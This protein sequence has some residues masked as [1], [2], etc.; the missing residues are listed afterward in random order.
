MVL[1]ILYA[2]YHDKTGMR[3]TRRDVRVLQYGCIGKLDIHFGCFALFIDFF[4]LSP[5][6][7]RR[8]GRSARASVTFTRV[9]CHVR[10][11]PVRRVDSESLKDAKGHGMETRG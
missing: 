6:W 10:T 2:R 1:S 8:G 4:S 5:I 7:K 9:L 3:R 11:H